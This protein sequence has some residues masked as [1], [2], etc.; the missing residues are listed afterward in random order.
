MNRAPT[1]ISVPP[2]RSQHGDGVRRQRRRKTKKRKSRRGGKRKTNVIGK[3][4][5]IC[6]LIRSLLKG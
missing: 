5:A 6:R 2:P 4:L 1:T 3:G